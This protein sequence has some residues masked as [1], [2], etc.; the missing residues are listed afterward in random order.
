[1]TIAAM[2]IGVGLDYSIHIRQRYREERGIGQNPRD[3]MN[4]AI[5]HSGRAL[6]GSAATTGLGFGVLSFADMNLFSMYGILSALMI[7]FAFLGAII[8][9]PGLLLLGDKKIYT[10]NNILPVESNPV[11][12]GTGKLD[13]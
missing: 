10:T 4:R 1:V 12:N 13:P 8:V 11:R 6:F 9:L 7:M 2:T 5:D 3:S